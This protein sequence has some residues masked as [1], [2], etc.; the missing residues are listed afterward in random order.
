MA[1]FPLSGVLR[2]VPPAK[3]Q[4]YVSAQPLV[5]P[6]SEKKHLISELDTQSFHRNIVDGQLLT[7]LIKSLENKSLDPW[8]LFSN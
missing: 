7:T 1:I 5:R 4:V 3:Y 6:C 2:G 8:T